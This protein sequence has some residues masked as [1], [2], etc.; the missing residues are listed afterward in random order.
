M[1]YAF[2]LIKLNED[3]TVT[4]KLYSLTENQY[5]EMVEYFGEPLDE[6]TGPLGD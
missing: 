6:H 5:N 2:T 3:G 4:T 1:I